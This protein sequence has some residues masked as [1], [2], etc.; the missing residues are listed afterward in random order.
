MKLSRVS[1]IQLEGVF[2]VKFQEKCSLEEAAVFLAAEY[3]GAVGVHVDPK[4]PIDVGSDV[5]YYTLEKE[6]NAPV[7]Q[8]TS[9]SPESD[10]RFTLRKGKYGGSFRKFYDYLEGKLR[11]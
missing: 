6:Q 5:A 1:T 10:N 7:L 3:E 9:I 2:C 11:E 8:I 4:G